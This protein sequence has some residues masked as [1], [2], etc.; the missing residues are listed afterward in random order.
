MLIFLCRG[1]IIYAYYLANLFMNMFML[2][3]NI[4]KNL[5]SQIGVLISHGTFHLPRV[6]EEINFTHFII[7]ITQGTAGN[8]S[9][10]SKL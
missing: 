10:F 5:S 8:A 7:R 6:V 3:T 4:F 2:I 1:V 9:N